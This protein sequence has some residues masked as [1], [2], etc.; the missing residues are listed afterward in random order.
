MRGKNYNP[1]NTTR[2]NRVIKKK[3]GEIKMT[4]WVCDSKKFLKQKHKK[5]KMLKV[6]Q[7]IQKID[8]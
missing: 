6:N 4:T 2:Q 8:K 7:K 3:N 5:V 1:I